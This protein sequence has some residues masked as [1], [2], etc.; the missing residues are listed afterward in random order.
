MRRVTRS[1]TALGV[2]LTLGAGAAA[3]AS[4]ATAAQY[5]RQA[6]AICRAT[7]AKL[8]KV[9]HPTQASEVGRTL[10]L[11][12]AYYKQQ[13]SRLAALHPPSTLRSLHKKA[14][15]LDQAQVSLLQKVVVAV[16]AG[17]DPQ[18]AYSKV[19]SGFA[20]LGAAEA[21]TWRKLRVTACANE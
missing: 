16:D 9:P 5:R 10:K 6:G 13:H 18:K 11:G 20:T 1:V 14:L 8:S 7:T 15:A 2:A 21:A 19:S 17:V 3:A 12:L 4:Q